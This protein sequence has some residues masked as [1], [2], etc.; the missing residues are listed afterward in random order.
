MDEHLVTLARFDWALQA[1]LARCRL[2]ASGIEAFLPDE[3]TTSLCWHYARALGGIRLQVNQED[4]DDADAILEDSS[5]PPGEPILTAHEQ[6]TDRALRSAVFGTILFPL[7][8]Y[9]LYLLLPVFG[10]RSPLGPTERRDTVAALILIGL[11]TALPAALLMLM[12]LS[13]L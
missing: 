1:D 3:Y 8:L 4:A 13:H 2:A 5:Q 10:W 7:G 11:E 9:A 6:V 12:M